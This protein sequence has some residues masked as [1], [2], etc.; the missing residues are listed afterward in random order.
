MLLDAKQLKHFNSRPIRSWYGRSHYLSL[1]ASAGCLSRISSG[2]KKE[3][4]RGI[5]CSFRYFARIL[6]SVTHSEA[7]SMRWGTLGILGSSA[8]SLFFFF[9]SIYIYI[10]IYFEKFARSAYSTRGP[11]E[12]GLTRHVF[13]LAAQKVI[14]VLLLPPVYALLSLLL[15]FDSLIAH[16]CDTASSHRY[17]V[18]PP[19]ANSTAACWESERII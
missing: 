7:S 19:Q 16:P 6:F 15:F 2:A 8:F 3:E 4:R 12:R 14:V 13:H 5:G 1:Y 9:L 17:P 11:S 18:F 10:Y